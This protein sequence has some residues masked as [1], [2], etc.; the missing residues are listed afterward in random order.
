MKAV[1]LQV[2]YSQA[3]LV[4][5]GAICRLVYPELPI[6]KAMRA[7]IIQELKRM[8]AG[9]TLLPAQAP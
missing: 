1:R 6:K 4:L 8:N 9:S 3:E 2:S 5:I 7:L